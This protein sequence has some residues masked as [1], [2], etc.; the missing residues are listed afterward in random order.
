ML[1]KISGGILMYV[2]LTLF[3]AMSHSSCGNETLSM[4]HI[5]GSGAALIIV[6]VFFLLM[7]LAIYLLED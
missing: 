7:R 4:K 1:K 6:G 5:Y 3:F 2:L